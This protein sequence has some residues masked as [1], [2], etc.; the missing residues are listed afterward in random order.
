MLISIILIYV[1][2]IQQAYGEIM[3]KS[4][5]D[6]ES[7]RKY[8]EGLRALRFEEKKRK[9]RSVRELA[10]YLCSMKVKEVLNEHGVFGCELVNYTSFARKILGEVF[11]NGAEF[12]DDLLDCYEKVWIKRFGV[13]PE[14]LKEAE[15]IILATLENM[16]KIEL[17]YLRMHNPEEYKKRLE[18][19][20]EKEREE[21][22]SSE[23][24]TLEE[25]LRR[26]RQKYKIT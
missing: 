6:L 20:E 18:Q 3:S 11:T 12:L 8:F 14:L 9:C 2:H 26:I 25:K 5:V 17:E 23:A 16:D 19:L 4:G 10:H 13:K 24:K 15:F 22:E 1:L 7:L 21:I